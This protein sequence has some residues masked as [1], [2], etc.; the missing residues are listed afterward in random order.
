MLVIV[1]LNWNAVTVSSDAPSGVS[2]VLVSER[3]SA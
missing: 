1:A 3:V 2:D